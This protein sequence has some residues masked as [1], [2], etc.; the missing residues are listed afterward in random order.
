DQPPFAVNFVGFRGK[1]LHWRL[2]KG[3]ETTGHEVSCQ[4]AESGTT[5]ELKVPSR[6]YNA[7]S[8]IAPFVPSILRADTRSA[9]T[10]SPPTI[11][12]CSELNAAATTWRGN[13]VQ[14]WLN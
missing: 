14:D 8:F 6:H 1:R 2:E 13:F 10:R 9:P 5:R 3:T 11:S 4:P 12:N 7:P